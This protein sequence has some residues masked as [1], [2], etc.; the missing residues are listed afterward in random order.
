MFLSCLLSCLCR[1]RVLL[2]PN[3]HPHLH[4]ENKKNASRVASLAITMTL[5]EQQL[6]LVVQTLAKQEKM[7]KKQ[8]KRAK[9]EVMDLVERAKLAAKKLAKLAPRP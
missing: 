4:R 8:V 3:E 5:A 2:S 1:A 7:A 9:Q 6:V